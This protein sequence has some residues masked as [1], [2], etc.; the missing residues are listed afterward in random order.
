MP[1]VIERLI[2]TYIELRHEDERFVDTVQRLGVEPFK[3][4]VYATTH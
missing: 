1:D 4:R 3:E 2:E